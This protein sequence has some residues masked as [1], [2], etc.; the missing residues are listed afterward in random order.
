M[1][2][3]LSAACS[4]LTTCLRFF[5]DVL[6]S[7]R[8]LFSDT[9]KSLGTPPLAATAL[10]VRPCCDGPC[11]RAAGPMAARG[12]VWTRPSSSLVRKAVAAGLWVC[13]AVGRFCGWAREVGRCVEDLLLATLGS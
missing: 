5:E 10:S 6:C 8:L 13:A 9:E 4:V 1:V 12:D 7:L 3:V 2:S 11:G